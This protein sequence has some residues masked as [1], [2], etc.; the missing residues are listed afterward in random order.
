MENDARVALV[1][2][3]NATSKKLMI[4]AANGP[5]V[6]LTRDINGV[7][8]VRI[9]TFLLKLPIF[10]LRFMFFRFKVIYVVNFNSQAFP[11]ALALIPR[12]GF[13]RKGYRTTH[14]SINTLHLCRAQL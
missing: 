5:M 3:E 11:V 10:Y 4:S 14:F 13:P 6:V 8:L 7:H 1:G 2:E 12:F 9:N